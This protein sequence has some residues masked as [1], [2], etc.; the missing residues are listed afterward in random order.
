M[1]KR[2][3]T[4]AVA[5]LGVA[6][7]ANAQDSKKDEQS[8]IE[9]EIQVKIER[10]IA[11]AEKQVER[12]EADA[13]T[14]IH[15]AMQSTG[16]AGGAIGHGDGLE[17]IG[18]TV[19]TDGSGPAR[20]WTWSRAGASDLPKTR[21]SFEFTDAPIKD[22]FEQILKAQKLSFAVDGDLPDTKVTASAKNVTLGAALDLISDIAGVGWVKETANGKT[23]I[24]VG[25]NVR[26]SSAFQ[27]FGEDGGL[28][29]LT[30]GG[31][32]GIPSLPFAGATM[33]NFKVEI[34]DVGAAMGY[35]A[36]MLGA[37]QSFTCPHCKGKVSIVR[38]PKIAKCPKCGE[39]LAPNWQFCPK[40]GAKRQA[41]KDD[42]QFCPLCGKRV[43]IEQMENAA[44]QE[45][46]KK[47]EEL[48]KLE[49][50]KKLKGDA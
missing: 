15:L 8:Q 6:A 31:K 44:K 43:D 29:W 23:T 32:P 36:I 4:A 7:V 19:T 37:R 28:K 41:S 1:S 22:A 46:M 17:H 34:P 39:V 26:A 9:H 16:A 35:R 18:V 27:V 24:K 3:W 47:L 20:V 14:A 30:P 2:Y 49:E 12:A 21:V 42:W 40:D 45:Q 10:Q 5:L 13:C 11:E 38:E 48:K 33:P 25:K 50:Q